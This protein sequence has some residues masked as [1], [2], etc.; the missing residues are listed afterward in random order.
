MG[1]GGSQFSD[2]YDGS[3]VTTNYKFSYFAAVPARLAID[4]GAACTCSSFRW[5]SEETTGRAKF[6]EVQSSTDDSTYTAATLT[7]AYDGATL[8]SPAT[9]AMASNV[10]EFQGV[11]FAPITARYWGVNMVD[12]TYS[13]TSDNKGGVAEIEVYCTACT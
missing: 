7:G 2:L 4:L 6:F 10:N 11:R 3:T 12:E 9:R 13:G 5:F 1:T 8:D